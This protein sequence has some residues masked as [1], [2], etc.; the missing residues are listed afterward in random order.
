MT[1]VMLA[2]ETIEKLI[3]DVLEGIIGDTPVSVQLDAA[4]SQMATKEDVSS[5]LKEVRHI[6]KQLDTLY[7]LVGDVA[8]SEQINIAIESSKQV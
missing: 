7:E 4:L 5:L 1:N 2:R 6:R 3:Y 8:V